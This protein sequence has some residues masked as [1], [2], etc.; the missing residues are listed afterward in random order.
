MPGTL[1]DRALVLIAVVMLAGFVGLVMSGNRRPTVSSDELD[2]TFDAVNAVDIDGRMV[3][4]VRK[5]D[6]LTLVNVWATWC[7]PCIEEIPDLVALALALGDRL[8]IIGISLD[9]NA[10]E[11][12]REFLRFHRVPYPVILRSALDGDQIPFGEA[13]PTT[14]LLDARGSIIKKYVG[15]INKA[16][17]ESDIKS[18]GQGGR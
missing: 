6:G 3:D 7:A 16:Q 1:S 14:F 13:V 11:S 9:E 8:K 17:L 5:R 15:R 2:F 4:F 10:S 12:F 18:A